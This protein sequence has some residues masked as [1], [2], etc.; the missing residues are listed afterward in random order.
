MFEKLS[1]LIFFST[2]ENH[3]LSA[4]AKK[5]SEFSEAIS[6]FYIEAG[7]L[8]D[9]KPYQFNGESILAYR[10]LPDTFINSL[11]LE[12]EILTR[13]PCSYTVTYQSLIYI[14]QVFIKF[15]NVSIEFSVSSY[16]LSRLNRKNTV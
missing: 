10:F 9:R 11:L 7:S 16:Y 3:D 8:E 13:K 15:I 6:K 5:N 1:N 2:L 14:D 4:P 12:V